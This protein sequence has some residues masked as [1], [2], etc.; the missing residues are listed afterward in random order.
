MAPPTLC[1]FTIAFSINSVLPQIIEPIGADS[2]F[3]RQNETE[4]KQEPDN[5]TIGIKCPECNHKFSFA[6]G[7]DVKKIKCPNCG[8][9][10]VLG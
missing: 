9:E 2:P 5:K 6:L 8:K 10:G 4:E 7:E 3:E 1:L